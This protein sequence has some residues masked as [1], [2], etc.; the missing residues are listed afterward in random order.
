MSAIPRNVYKVSPGAGLDIPGYRDLVR[1]FES[2]RS[3]VFTG[4]RIEDSKKV[5]LKIL[6][7]DFLEKNE[8]ARY[9]NQYAILSEHKLTCA[10]LVLDFDKYLSAPML[11]FEDRGG[12]ALSQTLASGTLTLL[13]GLDVAQKIAKALVEIHAQRIIHKDLNP[14]NILYAR[15]TGEVKIIDFGISTRLER[16]QAD[17]STRGV[18]EGSLPYMSPE[19]TGR[20]NK[21][22]DYRSDFYSFGVTLF[23]MFTGRLPFD[24]SDPLRLIHYHIA[25]RPFPP[26]SFKNEIPEMLSDLILK[27]MAKNA[28]DRYQSAWGI[29]ADLAKIFRALKD[30]GE[31][32]KFPLALQDVPDRFHVPEL[33]Y[34]RQK[35]VTHLSRV[36][37]RAETGGLELCFVSGYAGIGKT[38]LIK[39]LEK[40]VSV[41]G[42]NMIGGKFDA[43]RR[44]T[45]YSALVEAFRE[46]IRQLLGE[47]EAM[48]VQWRDTILTALGAN[49]QI[50]IDV[51][52]ELELILGTQTKA[53]QLGPNESDKRFKLVFKNFVSVFC[54]PGKPLVIHLDDLQWIDSASLSLIGSLFEDRRMKNFMLIGSFRDN[55]LSAHHPLLIFIEE[56]KKT[57]IPLEFIKLSTLNHKELEKWI[58]DAM[59]C[60]TERVSP[61]STLVLEKT[62]GNPFFAGEFL[63]ALYT[64]KLI[65]FNTD[66]GIWDW[67]LFRIRA[68]NMTDNV[69]EL[70][71]GRIG[72]LSP[73]GRS[74]LQLAACIGQTFDLLTLADISGKTLSGAAAAIREPVAQGFL[75]PVGDSYRLLEL[76]IPLDDRTLTIEYRFGHD[77]I[78]QA[79]FD[80]I[81]AGERSAIRYRTGHTLLKREKVDEHIFAITQ[82]L[83]ASVM[84]LKDEAER[85]VL[86]QLNLKAA[87][88][89]KDTAAYQSA[90]EYLQTAMTLEKDSDWQEHYPILMELHRE[91]GTVAFLAKSY[92]LMKNSVDVTLKRSLTLLEKIP[93]YETLVHAA[94]ARNDM[95]EAIALGKTILRELGISLPENPGLIR[96][97][98]S[99]FYTKFKLRSYSQEDLLNLPVM[100][101][102]IEIARMRFLYAMA[103]TIY[104]FFPKQVP[105]ITSTLVRKSL[106]HGNSPTSALAYT[107]YGMIMAAMVGDVKEGYRL[108][109]LGLKIYEK[110]QAKSIEAATLVCFNVFV[111]PW[112]DHVR[113]TLTPL[114][115]AHQSGMDSGDFE[116]AAHAAMGYCNRS[117]FVGVDLKTLHVDLLKFTLVIE[118]L[119]HRVDLDQT[120]LLHQMVHNFTEQRAN[121]CDLRGDTFDDERMLTIYQRNNDHAGQFSIY[122]FRVI[123]AYHFD[124]DEDALRYARAAEPSFK[125]V[126]G[127]LSAAV[128]NS[129]YALVLIDRYQIAPRAERSEIKG[130][131]NKILKKYKKWAKSAPMNFGHKLDLI[132]AEWLSASGK[133]YEAQLHYDAAIAGA[134]NEQYLHDEALANELAAKFHLKHGRQ[135]AGHAYMK[136]ARY[137][138]ER[139][140]ASAK[141]RQLEELYPHVLTSANAERALTGSLATM[142]SSTIDITTLKRALLAIAEENVH[143]RMLAKIISSAIEFAGAQKG[144]LMLRKDGEF[145]IEAEHSVDNDEPEIL[146][147]T[148][149]DHA[150]TISRMAVNYVKR[151][152]K[153][154]VID[155][156]SE[157]QDLLPGLHREAYIEKNKVL[158]ILCIPITV[159]I[160]EDSQIV[161][162]LYLE[163][164]RA[165]GTFTSERIETLEIICL[166]AAGRLELSV[167]AATDGLTGLFNH[168]YFQNMLAQE[169]VQSQRAGRNLS[170][171]LIDID[172]F[173]KFNDQ[174]G[175]QI[176]DLVLKKVAGAIRDTCRKSD[177]VARYGGEEMAVILPETS[178]EMGAMV[179]ERI[180][181]AIESLQ[182]A[183]GDHILSVTISLGLSSLSEMYRQ[184]DVLIS[185]ADEALY[186]SK[187]AGR[188]RVT[189]A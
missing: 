170:L 25:K 103:Q 179:A 28:E 43:F 105:L 85:I 62:G 83:N 80:E 50:M 100:T 77:R 128:F 22:V 99:L 49:T 151:S 149:V 136:R 36:L 125:S 78:Q 132:Q 40:S 12:R 169:L 182:I 110:F 135:T 9:K 27:L 111:R 137:N 89:A 147:S 122:F 88:K 184:K 61:L 17:I 102:P 47:P 66:K 70:M 39:N 54:M 37:S 32:E 130:T 148:A 143:S 55:D 6:Q 167:K 20:M 106:T 45:P 60:S 108:G 44:S 94:T 175:H 104:L 7:E 92:T 163:N 178:P 34:G 93:A 140:G 109:E 173:K 71:K 41:I 2:P 126:M 156:A 86:I 91:M 79:A 48:L 72:Q 118:Q 141:V 121:P 24:A 56:M 189:V 134:R 153:G 64:S 29:A 161:G 187:H 31:V 117:F 87:G 30:I 96:V 73:E 107:S 165:S 84:H 23:E 162:F 76:D 176:G 98:L 188:N 185:K 164:N 3:R 18:T 69:I 74:I 119:G 116:F 11:V 155:N 181:K 168:D 123:L 15:E 52:P 127:T 33:L 82:H 186:K 63:R 142:S 57:D 160:G 58:S 131:V 19:Q 129:Y 112:K 174:W 38:S 154:L 16:E 146:Q 124:R 21:F 114:L 101:D 46:L 115:S 13:E 144:V 67:H 95:Q 68:S 8:I 1:V 10:P 5:I 177:V 90:L 180:R 75:V 35:E 171:L 53:A 166:A 183:H 51:I 145:Y 120:K 138:Y 97:A 152:R 157:A 26:R 158:S 59:H 42:G 139:W 14:S 159:G 65:Y 172:H 133:L 81:A 4:V 113:S 150:H